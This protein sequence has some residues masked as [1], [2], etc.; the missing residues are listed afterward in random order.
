MCY[1]SKDNEGKGAQELQEYFELRNRLSLWPSYI[2]LKMDIPKPVRPYEWFSVRF[3]VISWFGLIV[4]TSISIQNPV[5]SAC[6]ATIDS[7]NP[8]K[9]AISTHNTVERLKYIGESFYKR[10]GDRFGINGV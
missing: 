6:L 3:F 4:E 2:I 5:W 10:K 8:S 9:S 1:P 7:S